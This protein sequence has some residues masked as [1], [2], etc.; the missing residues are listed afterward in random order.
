MNHKGF[1]IIYTSDYDE[2][3]ERIMFN[4]KT[5]DLP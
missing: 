2:R 5:R 1:I 3:G 4:L